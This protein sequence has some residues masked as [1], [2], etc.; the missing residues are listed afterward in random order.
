MLYFLLFYFLVFIFFPLVS[1]VNMLNLLSTFNKTHL[2]N[3]AENLTSEQLLVP[4][5]ASCWFPLR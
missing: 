3:L 5:F 2:P 1:L 4:P